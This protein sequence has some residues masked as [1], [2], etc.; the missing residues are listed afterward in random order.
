ML[1]DCADDVDTQARRSRRS[2]FIT[3]E[4]D[5]PTNESRVGRDQGSVEVHFGSVVEPAL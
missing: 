1:S 4:I 5:M 2:A 3:V